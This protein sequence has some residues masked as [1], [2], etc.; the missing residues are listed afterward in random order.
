M[1]INNIESTITAIDMIFQFLN[2]NEGDSGETY[3]KDKNGNGFQADMGYMYEGLEDFKKYL[4]KL[5]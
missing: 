2:D 3:W 5:N 4:L 1:N